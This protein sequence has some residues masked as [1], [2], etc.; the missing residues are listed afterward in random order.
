M[1]PSSSGVHGDKAQARL[2]RTQK[3]AIIRVAA[4]ATAR[5]YSWM[6]PPSSGRA[7]PAKAQASSEIKCEQYSP[8]RPGAERATLCARAGVVVHDDPKNDDAVRVE[9]RVHNEAGVSCRLSVLLPSMLYGV[10]VDMSSS[11]WNRC[12]FHW[13]HF[14]ACSRLPWMHRTVSRP[15]CSAARVETRACPSRQ[16]AGRLGSPRRPRAAP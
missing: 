4:Q 11:C 8:S 16:S 2:G 5:R 14:T 15:D 13:R 1:S 3:G 10:Q 7:L 9:Y 6:R 12:A